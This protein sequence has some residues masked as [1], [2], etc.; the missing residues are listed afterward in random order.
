[1]I[2]GNDYLAGIS[3][4]DDFSILFKIKK[5]DVATHCVVPLSFSTHFFNLY[6]LTDGA[7]FQFLV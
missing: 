3:G 7:T 6:V 1:M 5:C 4:W 2:C